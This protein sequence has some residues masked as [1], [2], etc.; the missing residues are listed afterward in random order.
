MPCAEGHSTASCLRLAITIV[1][2]LLKS[3]F[4]LLYIQTAWLVR[5][6]DCKVICNTRLSQN[7]THWL[8]TLTGHWLEFE[9]EVLVLKLQKNFVNQSQIERKHSNSLKKHLKA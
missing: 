5:Y 2:T 3:C 1:N 4:Y 9:N 6:L 8:C 7:H